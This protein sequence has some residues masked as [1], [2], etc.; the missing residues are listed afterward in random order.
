MAVLDKHFPGEIPMEFENHSD[1]IF[2]NLEIRTITTQKVDYASKMMEQM[3]VVSLILSKVYSHWYGYRYWTCDLYSVRVCN[4]VIRIYPPPC[5]FSLPN[6]PFPDQGLF[7]SVHACQ[8]LR[9]FFVV[10]YLSIFTTHLRSGKFHTKPAKR[11]DHAHDTLINSN[12]SQINRSRGYKLDILIW[13]LIFQISLNF[14]ITSVSGHGDSQCMGSN[15]PVACKLSIFS[16]PN[17]IVGRVSMYCQWLVVPTGHF[18]MLFRPGP[19]PTFTYRQSHNCA[20]ELIT[21]PTSFFS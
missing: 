18:H 14:T 2:S 17:F 8:I 20:L 11:G 3:G 16:P 4:S 12:I 13:C 21:R 1:N 9:P 10:V 7:T 6:F 19:F 5:A 15:R